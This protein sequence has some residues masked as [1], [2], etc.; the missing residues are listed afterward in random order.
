MKNTDGE[1][2]EIINNS[3]SPYDQ[4]FSSSRPVPVFTIER[5][6]DT[7]SEVFHGLRR[8]SYRHLKV[9]K[10]EEFEKEKKKLATSNTF[11]PLACN[12]HHLSKLTTVACRPWASMNFSVTEEVL[13]P[14]GVCVTME[15]FT[16]GENITLAKGINVE[17]RWHF[18]Q[19][20]RVVIQTP[21]IFI[22]GKLTITSQHIIQGPGNEKVKFIMMGD[23]DQLLVPNTQN[24]HLCGGEGYAC[25]VGPRAIVVAGGQVD[26]VGLMNGCPSWVRLAD[27]NSAHG[28]YTL[29]PD[30][31]TKSW[32][33]V[34][35]MCNNLADANPF[36]SYSPQQT[37]TRI[38][39][40]S[41]NAYYYKITGRN[42]PWSSISFNINPHCAVPGHM[43]TFQSKVV[44]LSATP[45]KMSVHVKIFKQDAVNRH[46]PP[47]ILKICDCPASSIA[48]GWVQC[49]CD[50]TLPSQFA[51]SDKVEVFF[52]TSTDKT[53]DVAYKGIS[54][55]YKKNAPEATMTLAAAVEKCWG[56]GAEVALTQHAFSNQEDLTTAAA[57]VLPRIV[58]N[59]ATTGL[60]FSGI[61][62][63]ELL[64]TAATR[65]QATEAILLNRNI[66]F[67]NEGGASATVG[68]HFMILNTPNVEQRIEGVALVGFGQEGVKG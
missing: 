28:S 30:V 52:S 46:Q 40:P 23:E 20:V 8:S 21:H 65:E 2:W 67:F 53:S 5:V 62:H 9:S 45:D 11:Q 35:H 13:I 54:F 38:Y 4:Y 17:G 44:L 15:G 64:T 32:Q 26:I 50:V 16:K 57:A 25:N 47:I 33:M 48:I 58:N 27:S 60:V 29:D 6:N 34:G 68:A 51:N 39:D 24:A 19:N 59:S 63:T 14:C 1:N 22:Q 3:G 55:F 43:Y 31:V 36:W 41:D 37:M 7:Y 42:A 12:G 18:P 66:V 10:G 61:H 56:R 49:L